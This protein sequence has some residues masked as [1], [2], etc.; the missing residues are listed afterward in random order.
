MDSNVILLA[1]AA[2]LITTETVLYQV[3][4]GNRAFLQNITCCH[5]SGN[6][7]ESCRVSF[8][9]AGVATAPQDYL[10]F[11]HVLASFDT[12][13][14]DL[15]FTLQAGYEVRVYVSAADITVLLFGCLV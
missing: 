12:L 10:L 6:P 15:K 9:K 5:R 11:D 3:P 4:S 7:N 13:F 8:S 1:Q 2:P 14:T